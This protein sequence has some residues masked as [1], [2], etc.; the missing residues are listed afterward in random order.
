[1]FKSKFMPIQE[2]TTK[3]GRVTG[4]KTLA[5]GAIFGVAALG[6]EALWAIARPV[7][8]LSEFDASGVEGPLSGR[9][10]H[11][12]VVGDSTTT[13]PGVSGPEDIWIRQ[14]ARRLEGHRVEISSFAVGGSKATDVVADQPQHAVKAAADIT[15]V[16][17][18]A[19][20]VLRGVSLRTFEPHIETIVE[21][22][23]AVSTVVVSGVGDLGTI[24][25]LLPPLDV[26]MRARG[27]A[28]DAVQERVARDHGAIKIDMWDLTTEEFR[29]NPEVFS[30][31]LFHPS[32]EGHRVWADAAFVTMAPL[33]G[34]DGS[35]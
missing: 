34:L 17:V 30:E 23:S 10:L 16:S 31:D 14:L 1:M 2:I 9:P 18:G 7:P 13:A 32:A 4:I 19:N 26:L 8:N 27:R 21:A 33:L 3:M 15:F 25:R 20:D 24:P 12:A 29:T 5:K 6:A 35:L 22:L 11:L 28:I